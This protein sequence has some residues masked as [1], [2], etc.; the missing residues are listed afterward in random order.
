MARPVSWRTITSIM[1]QHTLDSEDL[2]SAAHHDALGLC[3][4]GQG[5]QGPLGRSGLVEGPIAE[6]RLD[7]QPP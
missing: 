2:L 6:T 7:L 4:R 3:C 1:A 5:I